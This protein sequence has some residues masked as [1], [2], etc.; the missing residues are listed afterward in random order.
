MKPLN[1]Y[2]WIIIVLAICV[3]IYYFLFNPSLWGDEVS[4][5]NNLIDHGLHD[6][7]TGKLD[8]NQSAPPFYLF[9][10]KTMG[11]GFGYTELSLRFFAL[12]C[13]IGALLVFWKIARMLFSPSGEM[14][15]V[16]F[17]GFSS[18]L[19]YHSGE[20]K[21]YSTEVFASCVILYFSVRF[22][23]QL[24]YHNAIL[25]GCLFAILIGFAFPSIFVLAGVF[26]SM[27]LRGL[28]I[29][30]PDFTRSVLLCGCIWASAFAAYYIFVLSKSSSVDDMVRIWRTEF[31]PIPINKANILWFVHK[32]IFIFNN[33]FGLSIDTDFLPFI[34][35]R[36]RYVLYF[37]YFG[38]FTFL[39]GIYVFWKKSRY[40]LLLLALPVM[41]T[42]I[43]SSIH[44]YPLHERFLLFLMPNFYLILV[45]ALNLNAVINKGD[46]I[47]RWKVI[48]LL[49]GINVLYV[50]TNLFAKLI[51]P[52]G[53]GGDFKFSEFR[54][55]IH[56]IDANKKAN[57]RVYLAW[58]SPTKF[59]A[60]YS[61]VNHLQWCVVYGQPPEVNAKNEAEIEENIRK[62]I[63]TDFKHDSKVWFLL[64]SRAYP[65]PLTDIQGKTLQITQPLERIYR[66]V[67]G[68]KG[69]IT[70]TFSGN[71][72]KAY[73]VEF[74]DSS[75]SSA[76]QRK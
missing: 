71:P 13:G 53:F 20:V 41:F 24:N 75:K 62:M 45:E 9:V 5:A 17:F 12:V 36:R 34:P 46:W 42:L 23:H 60:Y 1:R 18:F 11:M 66:K 69:Q 19:I 73:L 7:F 31:L 39:A 47:V 4:L 56:Y 72:V 65:F 64:Q 54:E 76:E 58:N 8:A 68:E 74:N 52:R 44:K 70:R 16:F 15:A 6:L 14:V 28:W 30:K 22:R 38:F 25:W 33:P 2:A 59:Y 67:L 57:E 21:Q 40:V 32:I 27:L 29:K 35:I 61:R 37:N 10:V 51:D 50:L 48:Y 3:R 43:A 55:A 49:M 63:E 26:A